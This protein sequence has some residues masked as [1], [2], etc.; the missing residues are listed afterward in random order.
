MGSAT[1]E[2]L[3]VVVE[4]VSALGAKAKPVV[5]EELLSAARLISST[6]QLRGLL[7]DPSAPA[8]Q[9][10][11]IVDRVFGALGAPARG[12]L[13][14]AAQARFSSED[15]LVAA[16]EEAGIRV[17]AATSKAAV[18]EQ[19]FAFGRLITQ[20]AELELALSSKLGDPSA[21]GTLVETLLAGKADA[22]TV[23]ILAHLVRDPR[24]RRIRALV[25]D[26][27]SIVADV[28]GTRVATVTVASPLGASQLAALQKGL[29]ARYGAELSINQV[30]DPTVLG[31]VRVRVGTEVIDGS[32][33]ARLNDLR[34]QLAG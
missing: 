34:L 27:V 7:A 18:G 1:R 32:I 30:V 6:P 5:G 21:R 13:G 25:E 16:I 20:D 19:L 26:A 3:S 22:A 8:A 4:A 15:D 28:A 24:G 11:E 23:A 2:S 12:I 10:T 14:V 29:A 9:K 33:S 31:G 17:L